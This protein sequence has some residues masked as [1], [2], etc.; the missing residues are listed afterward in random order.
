MPKY[1]RRVVRRRTRTPYKGRSKPMSANKRYRKTFRKYIPRGQT[2][3]PRGAGPFSPSLY[4]KLKYF[5]IEEVTTSSSSLTGWGYRLNS[6]NDPDFTGTGAQP[7]FFDTL[8]GNDGANQPYGKYRVFGAK[9]TVSWMND[10]TSGTSLGLVAMSWRNANNSAP[11]SLA[12]ILELPNTKYR[13]IGVV[14]ANNGKAILK[15]YIPIAPLLG[16]KDLRDEDGTAALYNANPADQA[17]LDLFYQPYALGVST[18][19]FFRISI[20]YYCQFFEQNVNSQ[21]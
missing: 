13:D 21:S 6:L 12:D 16:I 10:N 4:T 3:S 1:T 7:R 2:L 17:I 5:D 11:G 8:C 9:V 14:N 15:K 18:T 20:T 19:I